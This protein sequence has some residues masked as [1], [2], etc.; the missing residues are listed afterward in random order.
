MFY[1]ESIVNNG[2]GKTFVYSGNPLVTGDLTIV[3]PSLANMDLE[4]GLGGVG[5]QQNAQTNTAYD[6]ASLGI[7]D[8]SASAQAASAGG[9]AAK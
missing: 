5:S 6:S 9:A 4:E 8:S 3:S 1:L 2:T 7:S